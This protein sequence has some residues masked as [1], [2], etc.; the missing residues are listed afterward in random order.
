MGPVFGKT[1]IIDLIL[2]FDNNK[3]LDINDLTNINKLQKLTEFELHVEG[4]NI[5][6]IT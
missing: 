6:N 5:T 3:L 2:H 4:N 1:N